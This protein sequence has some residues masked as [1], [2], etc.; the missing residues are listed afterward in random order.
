MGIL[1]AYFDR[2]DLSILKKKSGFK[3]QEISLP[4]CT[5]NSPRSASLRSKIFA[6][7]EGMDD[8]DKFFLECSKYIFPYGSS[9]GFES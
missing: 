7:F 6:D 5:I 4:S 1:G 3:I 2:D 8:F 9:G